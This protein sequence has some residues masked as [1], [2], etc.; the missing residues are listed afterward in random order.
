MTG[1]MGDLEAALCEWLGD[2]WTVTAEKRSDG[3]IDIAAAHPLSHGI[4]IEGVE[5]E[6]AVEFARRGWA[7]ERDN[8]ASAPLSV[9]HHN[10]V[11][12]VRVM[13]DAKRLDD[14]DRDVVATVL[15]GIGLLTRDE[16]NWVRLIEP[17]V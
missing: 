9:F 14:H 3:R 15:N 8:V 1:R 4:G 13:I 7:P 2:S 5:A 6:R 12:G 11:M 10:I 17:L 16:A